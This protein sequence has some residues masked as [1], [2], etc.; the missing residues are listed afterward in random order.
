M[1]GV[2][3]GMAILANRHIPVSGQCPICSGAAEDIKHLIF[4]CPRAEEV[5]RS[6]GILHIIENAMLVDRSGSVVLEELLRG[7]RNYPTH[8][9]Q[10]G[11][12]EIVVVGAWYIWWQRREAVKGEKVATPS[13]TSFKIL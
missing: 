3:P 13:L 12:K 11:T 6:L 8:S 10:V 1:D 4:S 7:N 2:I 5:W 9:S